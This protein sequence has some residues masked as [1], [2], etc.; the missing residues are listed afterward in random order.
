MSEVVSLF[1]EPLEALM[2]LKWASPRLMTVDDGDFVLDGKDESLGRFGPLFRDH[3]QDISEEDIGDFLDFNQNRH[4]TGLHRQKSNILQDMATL[5]KAIA[6]LSKSSRD[7]VARRFDTAELT[8][9]GFGEGIITPILFVMYPDTFAVWNSKSE[10]ALRRLGL[11]IVE[12]RGDTKGWKY[13]KVNS[14][15][16]QAANFL[17]I[18]LWTIDHHWH[19]IKVLDE[20]GNLL[21][22]IAEFKNSR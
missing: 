7:D 20:D 13:Y 18:D 19:A 9:T 15:I 8:V 4:W 12:D 16:K 17:E 2:F 11:W 21:P 10:Y 5:R 22:L 3:S 14:A 1:K 6:K